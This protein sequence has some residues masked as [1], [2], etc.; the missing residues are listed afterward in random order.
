MPDPFLT[1][2][3]EDP[4][5][6]TA[7]QDQINFETDAYHCPGDD[8]FI[9]AVAGISYTYNA[10]LAG[11][12]LDESWFKRRLGLDSAAVPVSYD[13]DGNRFEMQDGSQIV[14]PPFHVLRNLP[15]A[16]WH[17]GNYN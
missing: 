5:L 16:D 10:S 4:D 13:T 15:F 17:V 6:P 3:P 12:Q 9:H 8:G 11:R 2:F 7:I 1:S 14:A